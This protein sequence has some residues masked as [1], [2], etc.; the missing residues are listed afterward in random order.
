MKYV[1]RRLLHSP[2]FT[3]TTLLTL[4]IGIG[5]NTAIFSVIEGVLLKPLPFKNP[6]E[7]ISVRHSAPGINVPDLPASPSN[8][9]VYR[10]ENRV[11]EDIALWTYD[12]LNVTGLAEPQQIDGLDVTDGLLGILGVQPILGRSF[13]AKDDSAGSP[14]TCMIS[15]GYW[16]RSFGGDRGVIGRT[17][18]VDATPRE[19]IGVLPQGFQL[20]DRA[21]AMLLPLQFNRARTTLGNFSF[22]SVARMKPGVTLAQARTDIARMIPMVWPKFAPPGRG[23]KKMFEDARLAPNLRSLKDFVIGDIGNILW[24]LM[25]TIGIVLLIACANVA[26]LLLVRAE[27]RQQELSI[28]TALGA[29]QGRLAA[30]L[31]LESVTL[32]ILGGTI[33]LALA[34]GALR[35]LILF[36]PA[37]LPRLS[38]I[39]IDTNV[40]LFALAISVLSGV[41]F[42]LI[43]IFKYASGRVAGAI[44]QGGRGLSQSRERHRAR[45]VLVV[46]QV[47]LALVL[48]I[49]AGL[50]IRT[51]DAMRNVQAGFS[52]PEQVQAV[53][54]GIPTAQVKD[55]EA[56]LQMQRAILDKI[57]QIPGISSATFASTIPMDGNQSFDPIW[58]ED[59]PY[60]EGKLPPM[61]RY[62]FAAPGLFKTI[63]NPFLA[64]RD[65]T[66]TDILNKTPVAIL[67]ESL[68]KEY[69]G[70]AQAAVGKRIRETPESPWREVIGV[71]TDIR[72]EGVDQPASIAVYWPILAANFQGNPIQIRRGVTYAV[73]TPRAGSQSLVNEIRQ[74]IWSVN[75]D[76]PLERVRTLDELYRKSMAR[77]SFALVMLA[78][79]GGMALLLGIVG[80]YGVISYSVSQRTREI[81]IRMALGAEQPAVLRMFVGHGLKLVGIGVAVGLVAAYALTSGMK[82]L[83]YG[84]NAAD[85]LTYVG[86][87][88]VLGVAAA[89]ASYLPSR[90]A[91][92]V[93]PVVALRAE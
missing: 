40:L 44:R 16:Q 41:L 46:A 91:A 48:L 42:G 11:F 18:T 14:E 4:A 71:T 62:K 23:D 58:A 5:A 89:V 36:A 13:T 84:V 31:M 3:A 22:Q 81:G 27:G 2:L 73:R 60:Q 82:S 63:A 92:A 35:L 19:I 79:A 75:P 38:E 34:Y 87:S 50:M 9:F 54:I 43:P 66:W 25:G 70:S 80:I 88:L 17:V 37:N 83:L 65:F 55:P 68:A 10:E 32:G 85:P 45:S 74:A 69:W 52:N 57:A 59:R 6:E 7:L 51:F 15:Y 20:G 26:N 30:D 77:T 8:Y 78:M 93:D 64:G 56:V 12:S 72:D 28:R 29:S 49:G 86:V 47:A 53:S 1:L 39:S 67:S 21:P 90:R 24:V 61:R 76:L 33:G